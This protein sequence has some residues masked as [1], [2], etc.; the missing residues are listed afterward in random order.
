MIK[1]SVLVSPG[2]DQLSAV[3]LSQVSLCM[4]GGASSFFGGKGAKALS[5]PRHDVLRV[6]IGL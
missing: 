4:T 1:P 6:G 5:N 2:G 3:H